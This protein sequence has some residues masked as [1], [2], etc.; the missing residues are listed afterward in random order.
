MKTQISRNSHN[1]SRRYSGIYQQQGRMLTDADWNELVDIINARLSRVLR[2]VLGT[3]GSPELGQLAISGDVTNLQ[4]SNG[5]V[6]AGGLVARLLS[7]TPVTY[8]TQPDFPAAP[9][10]PMV[11]ERLY[12]DLWERP[13]LYLEDPMLRD[14]GLH[15]ADTCTRTRT[16]LQ[17]KRCPADMSLRDPYVNPGSGSAQL[18]LSQ[19]GAGSGAESPSMGNYLFRLEVHDVKGRASDPTEITLKWSSENAAEVH[20]NNESVPS[21]FWGNDWLYEFYNDQSELHLGVHLV[22]ADHFPARGQLNEGT[23]SPRPDSGTHPYVRRWDGKCVLSRSAAGW[24]LEGGWDRGAEL[25]TRTPRGVHGH[26]RIEEGVLHIDL[27]ELELAL[28]LNDLETSDSENV[29]QFFV[30]GDYWLA[31]VREYASAT[32]NIV[33]GAF[34]VGTSHRYVELGVIEAD[35][36]KPERWMRFPALTKLLSSAG[37][38]YVGTRDVSG[39]PRSLA[40]GNVQSQVAQLLG[41]LNTHATSG[42]HDGRYYTEEEVDFL[43]NAQKE[44]LQSE[45]RT[46]V[47]SGEH[48]DR[49]SRLAGDNTL[50]GENE[51][52]GKTTFTGESE[53][54]GVTTFTGESKFTSGTAFTGKS[55][56]SNAENSFAGKG[57]GLTNL[58]ASNLE[59]GTVPSGRISGVYSNITRVGTLDSLRVSGDMDLQKNLIKGVAFGTAVMTASFQGTLDTSS[60]ASISKRDGLLWMN[61]WGV[62][63]AF[64]DVRNND[65]SYGPNAFSVGG[66]LGVKASLGGVRAAG[67]TA[68]IMQGAPTGT[69]SQSG[70]YGFR[71]THNGTKRVLSGVVF[72]SSGAL[73]GEVLLDPDYSEGQSALFAIR[74][75]GLVT[76]FF[77]NGVSAGTLNINTNGSFATYSVRLENGDSTTTA[78]IA[79]SF[80]TIGTPLL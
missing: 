2:D 56:F 26:V 76:E 6:Y 58:N 36:F 72:G 10:R 66:F 71:V 55:T 44:L 35:G 30:A 51:F 5:T 17:I 33:E 22:A 11:G 79:V 75:A 54:T 49:Y 8:A 39:T 61:T 46:H 43:L 25:S 57:A 70:G 68:Y 20:A 31:P 62:A 34:P 53:F 23:P 29:S 28:T 69:D 48:D 16:M 78:N 67:H 52:T 21:H 59:T 80:L 3:G 18:T 15:G 19:R 77:V 45:L 13:V 74:R 63:N 65:V 50:T 32:P 60:N 38:S 12:A 24:S 9:G 27:Q 73:L 14:P 1:P 41:H 64:A 40:E 7:P 37:A 4:I 42:E 47:S